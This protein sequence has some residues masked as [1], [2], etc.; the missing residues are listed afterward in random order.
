MS[1]ISSMPSKVSA[2][3]LGNDDSLSLAEESKTLPKS[4]E[5]PNG[6]VRASTLTA[7]ALHEFNR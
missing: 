1:E 6:V 2:E 5:K 4:G 7:A 3:E